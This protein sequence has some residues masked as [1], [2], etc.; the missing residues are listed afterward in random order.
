[1]PQDHDSRPR[2]RFSVGRY[3]A[4]FLVVLIGIEALFML[5]VVEHP[6]FRGYLEAYAYLSGQL[7]QL[8][9]QEVQVIGSEILSGRASIEVQRGCDAFQP[10]ALLCANVLAFPA[11]WS[12]KVVGLLL[13]ISAILLVNLARIVSLYWLAAH[14]EG[15]FESAHS[16]VWPLGFILL[17]LALWLAW[18]RWTHR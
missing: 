13:G 15:L 4:T 10:T 7:L 6:W 3:I 11:R 12:H 17:S 18:A 8:L 2:T 5:F 14:H 9:G 16:S 1:M